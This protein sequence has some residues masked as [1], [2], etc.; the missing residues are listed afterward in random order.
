M[1]TRP[2]LD[3][4]PS[5][6][7]LPLNRFKQ[8]LEVPSAKPIEV[9]P[10]DDLNEHSRPIHQ[11]L[12]KKLQQITPLIKIDQDIQTSQRLKVLIQRH[13]RTLQPQPH[14]LVVRLRHLDE[15]HAPCFQIRDIA[16]DIV[17]AKRDVLDSRAAVEVD[18]FLDLALLLALGRLVDGHLDDVVR[19]AHDDALQRGVL[20]ANILVVDGPEAVKAEHILII[21]TDVFHLVPVLVA[22]AVVDMREVDGWQE[23]AEGIGGCCGGECDVAGEEGAGVGRVLLDER[24]RCVAVGLDGC[25]ADRAVGVFEGVGRGDGYGAGGDGGVVDG[26]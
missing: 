9:I 24:V 23:L 18:V 11:M 15:L 5:C 26:F 6:I 19:T 1:I 7:L 4:V 25:E 3:Q 21:V 14:R 10:L 2:Y 17:G 13:A 12:R 20:C 8:G 22:D 16:D